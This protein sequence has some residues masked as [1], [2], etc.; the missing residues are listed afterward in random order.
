MKKL[1]LCLVL[2]LAGCASIQNPLNITRLADI[3]SAY[4]I[5]L[6]AANAYRTVYTINPCTRSHPESATNYCARR[7]VVI[8]LQGA[9]RKAQI[10][11]RSARIFVANNPTLDAGSVIGVAQLAIDAMRQIE[12]QN[13]V[14]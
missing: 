6:A 9:D 3:E 8:L 10:A 7:S 4:G 13:G 14:R 1:W 2:V 11:L 5:V 12:Q